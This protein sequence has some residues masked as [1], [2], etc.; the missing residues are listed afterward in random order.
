ML[1]ILSLIS[2]WRIVNLVC[3]SWFSRVSIFDFKYWSWVVSYSCLLS[4]L[5][6][7]L[8]FSSSCFC[9]S[10]SW[11]LS[12]CF[13][14]SI[15]GLSSSSSSSSSSSV[16]NDLS[17]LSFF[18]RLSAF[19]T[20]SKSTSSVFWGLL[21]WLLSWLSSCSDSFFFVLVQHQGYHHH[22]HHHWYKTEF[23]I[24]F[25]LF[26]YL[27]HPLCWDLCPLLVYCL[28]LLISFSFSWTLLFV[29]QNDLISFSFFFFLQQHYHHYH[30]YHHNHPFQLSYL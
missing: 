25:L 8:N 24:Y 20:L 23:S 27:G 18:I 11:F 3:K 16:E 7:K 1:L 6:Y 13:L 21:P 17:W 2:V 30:H 9:I 26:G 19:R 28:S 22:H 4:L 15:S 14:V 29:L 12:C 10:L 5:C